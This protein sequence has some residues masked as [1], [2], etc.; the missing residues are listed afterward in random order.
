M[1]KTVKI[2]TLEK[3]D[4]TLIPL[5]RETFSRENIAIEIRS[6]HDTAYD[7]LFIGQKG[8]ADIYVMN[9]DADRSLEILN[10]LLADLSSSL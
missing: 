4:E 6:K 7:G 1:E 5:I 9:E 10:D 8:L 3:K 2:F